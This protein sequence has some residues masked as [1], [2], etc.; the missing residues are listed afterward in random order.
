MII[1]ANSS[2]IKDIIDIEGKIFDN[3]WSKQAFTNEIN[4]NIS[5]NWVYILDSKL[6][7][8]LFGWHI[9]DEFHINNIAVQ[10][11]FRRLGIA[12]KMINNIISKLILKNVFLEVSKLNSNAIL[13]YE[14][15]GFKKQ[16]IREKYYSDSSDAILYRMELK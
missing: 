2:H 10:K 8:Y 6:I 7:G 3:P 16:G 14:N 9:D 15:L 13:L 4:S 1:K 12:K 5:S 11:K